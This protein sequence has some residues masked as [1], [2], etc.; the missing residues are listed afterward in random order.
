MLLLQCSFEPGSDGQTLV[1]SKGPGN[2]LQPNRQPLRVGAAAY[3]HGGPACQVIGQGV[4]VRQHVLGFVVAKGRVRIDGTN[5]NVKVRKVAEH[6]TAI[7]IPQIEG[8]IEFRLIDGRPSLGLTGGDLWRWL[9]RV[10][11]FK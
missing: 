8:V 7:V 9:F 10:A 3:D 5:K 6:G 11:I 1:F 2:N 4:A